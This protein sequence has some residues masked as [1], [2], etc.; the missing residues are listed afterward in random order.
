MDK[1]EDIN[2]PTKYVN[3]IATCWEMPAE[4]LAD[5]FDACD[6]IEDRNIAV[7]MECFDLYMRV[8]HNIDNFFDL[9]AKKQSTLFDKNY[10]NFLAE[11]V[12]MRYF[13]E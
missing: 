13:Y 9:T 8:V 1:I 3:F 7:L 5:I 6:T 4:V 11:S 12:K 10:D 2:L